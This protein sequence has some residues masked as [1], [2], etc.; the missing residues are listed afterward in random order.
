M[1]MDIILQHDYMPHEHAGS[2]LRDVGMKVL[3]VGVT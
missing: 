3:G 2:V 1:E